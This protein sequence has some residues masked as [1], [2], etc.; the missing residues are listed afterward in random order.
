MNMRAFSVSSAVNNLN[1]SAHYTDDYYDQLKGK[2]ML[3]SK[4]QSYKIEHHPKYEQLTYALSKLRY[5]P[6]DISKLNE[7]MKEL[8]VV[9]N[10]IE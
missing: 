6:L 2:Y 7:K 3:T 10:Y 8:A 9:N 5:Q 1:K 4:T